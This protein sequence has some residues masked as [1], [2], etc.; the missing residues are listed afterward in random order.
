MSKILV[1][2]VFLLSFPCWANVVGSDLQNFNP[3]TNGYGFITV[4][5][6]KTLSPL[7]L[8]VGTFLTYTTNSLPY[9]TVSNSPNNQTFSEPNDQLLYS[10]IHFGLGLLK[11]WWIIKGWDL[12]VGA[13]FLN[14]Q[15]IDQTNYLFSYGDTGIDDIRLNTKL[16]F[17]R[18]ATWGFSIGAGIDF[19]QIQNNPFA[20]DDPG[21]TVNLDAIVDVYLTKALQWAVNLGYRIRQ[22]GTPI[23][24]TGVTPM[25]DQ[26]TYSSALRY[27]I[28]EKGS[29]IIGEIYG[30]Y[31]TEDFTL[32]TDRQISNL[33]VLLGY[34]WRPLQAFDINLGV[35]TEAY[36]GLGSPDFR[37]FLGFNLRLGFLDNSKADRWV[38]PES[39]QYYSKKNQANEM[40]KD[41]EN[42]SDN[43]GVPD[44]IDQCPN[45]WAQNYVDEKG[46]NK[47]QQSSD[48]N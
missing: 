22:P 8:N 39:T 37:A 35:G 27:N 45:T 42:D 48:D 29:A 28:N 17:Y 21:P 41:L 26:V 43:D 18:D 14:A 25:P 30:S 12:G 36:H 4:T 20:G 24:N 47:S 6:S 7:E 11:D 23:P 34:R 3:N 2:L 16:N 40:E 10:Q 31:P 32:P 46:C 33:E 13:G 44:P 1:T 19:D 15:N 38:K 9:S 5:P